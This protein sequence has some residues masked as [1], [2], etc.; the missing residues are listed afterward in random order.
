M[1]PVLNDAAAGDGHTSA[2]S[3]AVSY[4]RPMLVTRA[5]LPACAVFF[6]VSRPRF[7]SKASQCARRS[8]SATG[9]RTRVAR[10]RAEY[11]NQLDYSGVV[12]GDRR[13]RQIRF[14]RIRALLSHVPC[15][16][17]TLL[18]LRRTVRTKFPHTRAAPGIEPG[19]SRTLSENHTTRPSSQC[20]PD[21]A[22]YPLACVLL[23]RSARLHFQRPRA[24]C[25][26]TGN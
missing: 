8:Y 11:P 7:E 1:R 17:H 21:L 23:R 9:T 25:S 19:T 5:R 20:C 15:S 4:K 2:C 16:C 14:I 13:P 12:T 24:K 26:A 10:V 18:L 22:L 6:Y 3:V